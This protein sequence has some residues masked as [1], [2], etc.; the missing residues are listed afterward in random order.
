[1]TELEYHYFAT[2]ISV[3]TEQL[4]MTAKITEG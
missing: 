3:S 2:S 4:S 1:M